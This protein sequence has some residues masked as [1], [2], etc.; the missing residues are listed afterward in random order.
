MLSI[1]DNKLKVE[2]FSDQMLILGA[3][4]Q[5][6]LRIIQIVYL[7]ENGSQGYNYRNIDKESYFG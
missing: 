3:Y 2:T 5:R 4:Y 7:A 6:L 1:K